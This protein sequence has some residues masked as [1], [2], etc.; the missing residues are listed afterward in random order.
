LEEL[1]E[2]QIIHLTGER[3]YA[4]IKDCY[5]R[6]G[7]IA[8]VYP[9]YENMAE[10]LAA[11]DL[12]IGRA[13]A[14]SIAELIAMKK[15]AIL[16]PISH[17]FR[18]HQLRNAKKTIVSKVRK[19]YPLDFNGKKFL[20]VGCAHGWVCVEFAKQGCLATGIDL[21]EIDLKM[22]KSRA[23]YGNSYK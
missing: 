21:N 5:V 2:Y 15:P 20:D 22:A 17:S 8:K 19:M 1:K 12:V 14:T 18:N 11:A 4:M 23:G 6:Y 7:L 13:G 10:L 16:I 3:D 9:F